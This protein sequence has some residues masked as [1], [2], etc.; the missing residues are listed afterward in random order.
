MKLIC[1][2]P[3][4]DFSDEEVAE[5]E[6]IYQEKEAEHQE[7]QKRQAFYASGINSDSYNASF[8]NF[9]AST[10]EHEELY[11]AAN[12]LVS[13]NILKALV[14]CG[15]NGT[16]KTYT[17]ACCLRE[18]G[19]KYRKSIEICMEYEDALKP[20]NR[21][22]KRQVMDRYIYAPFLVIDEVHRTPHSYE[23][24]VISYIVSERIESNRKTI[25]IGN[26]NTEEIKKVLDG[27]VMSRINRDGMIMELTGTDRRQER[28]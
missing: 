18:L 25:I 9:K 12:F 19:G 6:R 17:A 1:G 24:E 28:E 11:K 15:K 10:K 14:L 26:C 2:K 22:N 23:R 7:Y 3:V 27:A 4:F 8:K 13:M 5:L 20:Y 21:D 16:G